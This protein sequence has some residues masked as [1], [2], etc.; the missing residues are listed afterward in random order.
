M[1]RPRCSKIRLLAAAGLLAAFTPVVAAR[2][3][4][5][6]TQPT[7]ERPIS[8]TSA[9]VAG[10]STVVIAATGPLPKPVVGILE[11]PSRIY[12]DF[13]G[14]LGRTLVAPS[15]DQL[16][17]RVRAAQHSL[18]PLVT[19]VVIDLSSAARYSLDLSSQ[20]DG[21][22]GV[23]LSPRAGVPSPPATPAAT[24]T[25]SAQAQA[26][27]PAAKPA[28][29]RYRARIGA[30][31]DRFVPVRDVLQ[32]IDRQ[33]SVSVDRLVS[34]GAEL[35][36]MGAELNAMKPPRELQEGHDLLRN[37]AA[38][39]RTAVSLA[40]ATETSTARSN[41]ASAAAG[42]LILLGRAEGVLRRP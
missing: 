16:V 28:E 12:L 30:I 8:I 37:A 17:V 14:V 13:S 6:G 19:R 36:S 29:R 9:S 21:R 40:Q 3:T 31:L 41:A 4:G 24:S 32:L 5:Q 10:P 15:S 35:E 18:D 27:P 1:R 7:S 33:E 23:R 42:A 38:L 25:A 20:A 11:N 2:S 34:A 26:V 39:G 22:I